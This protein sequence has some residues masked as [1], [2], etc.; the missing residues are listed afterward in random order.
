MTRIRLDFVQSF[1]DRHGRVR[2]YF[3]RRGFKR[4][5]LPGLPG[6]QE[7]MAA[8]Q[9]ALAG[10]TAEPIKIG[11]S[12]TKPGTVNTTIVGFY[13]SA[14]FMNLRPI[15]QST[16]RGVLEAFRAKHGDKRV[17]MLERRHV[18]DLIAEKAGR[19][20]AQRNLLRMLKMLL[21]FAVEMDIRPDNPAA[22]V[23]LAHAKGDGFHT[24]SEDEIARFEE[25]HAIG[26]RARLAFGLLL[27]TAQR[28]A[29]VVRMGRQ[30]IRD[31]VV[32]VTQSKTGAS[33]AIPIHRAPSGNH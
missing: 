27:Y 6:S 2:H 1:I 12:R 10:V 9:A 4:I 17:A 8:Y 13:Q 11:A 18:R 30:H 14:A 29:D 25:R 16:Y 24:W 15:T 28:R 23:R 20:G 31:G 21:N 32:H 5:P 3:R 7:F 22:G 26:S 33:L 19:P